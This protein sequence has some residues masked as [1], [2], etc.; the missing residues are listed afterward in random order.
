MKCNSERDRQR[1]DGCFYIVTSDGFNISVWRWILWRKSKMWAGKRFDFWVSR[2]WLTQ[3]E[4]NSDLYR[5]VL[6]IGPDPLIPHRS[7]DSV[8]NV[9][10]TIQQIFLIKKYPSSNYESLC[11]QFQLLSP[12]LWCCCCCRA[13]FRLKTEF[14]SHE[15]PESTRENKEMSDF[16]FLLCYL[17]VLFLC[18]FLSTGK[19]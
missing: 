2:R 10:Q 5:T 9:W 7:E 17:S 18:C 15:C 16:R 11:V 3:Q 13:D 14:N 12:H 19:K 4:L 8:W 1:A 6:M